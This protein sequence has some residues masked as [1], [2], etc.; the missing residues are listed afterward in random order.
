MGESD[1]SKMCSAI[2]SDAE[3]TG[4]KDMCG[5]IVVSAHA[6]Y[7]KMY[8]RLESDLTEWYMSTV[9]AEMTNMTT[10]NQSST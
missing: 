1:R 7:Y 5:F 9:E 3:E 2:A 4:T 6:T 8:Q 10:K